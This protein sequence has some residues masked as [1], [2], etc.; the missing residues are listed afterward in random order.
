[1]HTASASSGFGGSTES[2]LEIAPSSLGN[3]GCQCH[4]FQ[5]GEI[6]ESKKLESITWPPITRFV[7][8]KNDCYSFVVA[9][10][11]EGDLGIVQLESHRES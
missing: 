10:A 3:T 8:I 6:N 5:F 2:W 4:S 7:S 9:L 1:M 11:S